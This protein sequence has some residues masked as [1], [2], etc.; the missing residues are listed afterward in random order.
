MAVL[1]RRAV[2]RRGSGVAGPVCTDVCRGSSAVPDCGAMIPQMSHRRHAYVLTVGSSKTTGRM[3]DP[4]PQQL[5]AD[6]LTTMSSLCRSGTNELGECHV[7]NGNRSPR[8]LNRCDI[9]SGARCSP[10]RFVV[11]GCDTSH[12]GQERRDQAC[13]ADRPTPSERG[14]AATCVIVPNWSVPMGGTTRSDERRYGQ[15]G[16]RHTRL[17]TD[18]SS[19]PG[20]TRLRG[21]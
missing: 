13:S 1:R 11:S 5:S 6:K 2:P 7:S 3:D 12:S 4:N 14:A 16:Y 21:E 18:G 15:I 8:R 19:P 9:S 20:R 10:S 17:G